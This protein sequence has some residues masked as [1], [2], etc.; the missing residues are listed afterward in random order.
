M[1]VYRE[2][3]HIVSILEQA[4]DAVESSGMAHEFV[5]V[6]DGSPDDTWRI[7]SEISSNFPN[8]AAV[9]LSRNF[10]KEAALCAGIEMARGDAVIVMDAD[11]QHPISLIPEMIR[12]WVDSGAAIV[13]GVKASRG[14]ETALNRVGARLFYSTWTR[15]SG[16]D[17]TA[18]SDFKLLDRRAVEAYLQMDERSV[19]F[20]GMTAWLGFERKQIPFE[21]AGRAGGKSTWSI[22]RLFRLALTGITAFSALPLQLVTL[23]GFLF[24]LF[25]LLFG[26]QTLYVLIEG[27]AV[28]G[29]ATIIFLLLIIGSALMISL[30]IIG[31]YVA[32]IYEEVKGRPRFVVSESIQS[33][34]KQGTLSRAE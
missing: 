6:D 30:G 10:G 9:R 7:L 12:Q 14:K 22:F 8:L 19:F 26:A 11:G 2:G 5:L 18:A 27:H 4:R 20:R 1:P 32:R 28:S 34:K 21:V 24:L 15:L 29:F 3:A 25:A 33:R 31:E 23:A 16:F 17:L 13:E